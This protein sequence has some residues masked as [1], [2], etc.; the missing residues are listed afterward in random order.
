[1]YGSE[2]VDMRLAVEI[3]KVLKYKLCMFGIDTMED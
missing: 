3:E 2:L 1:M